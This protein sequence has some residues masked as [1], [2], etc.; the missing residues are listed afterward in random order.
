MGYS[1]KSLFV[2][3]I[4]IILSLLAGAAI[5]KLSGAD[6]A[7]A[8]GA[9]FSGAFGDREAVARTLEKAT[10]LLFNG[11]AIA[12]A[13]KAGL[14]N[15]GAQGQFLFGAITAAA[16]GYMISGLPFY[17]HIPLVLFAGIAAGGIYCAIQGALKAYTGAHEVITGI[18]F[19]YV[20]INITDYLAKG[21][22][23][24]RAQGNIVPRTPLIAESCRLPQ[25]LDMPSGF[26]LAII[27]ALLCWWFLKQSVKG[28]EIRMS[29][30]NM[31]ASRY[32][33]INTKRILIITMLCSGLLA[34]LGG[35]VETTGIVFRYQPGFNTGLGFEGI[36]IALL[37]R[38]HPLGVIPAALLIG[39]MKSGASM[40]QFTAEVPTEIIDVIQ[41][42]ILFF[43]GADLVIKKIIPGLKKTGTI[44][45]SSGWGKTA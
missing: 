8:F 18:M 44:S 19:N 10:P 27:V 34:G 36:T 11:L 3:I 2:P 28:F 20:A 33:G 15:I 14:F 24:D 37:G 29:G 35:A 13:L 41:A 1:I 22:L 16:A 40:M 4:S 25:F 39:A 26:F 9:L 38:A 43:V 6:P 42:L 21:P 12:F 23:M 5:L 45:I 17:I 31:D 30:S 7:E 32:A